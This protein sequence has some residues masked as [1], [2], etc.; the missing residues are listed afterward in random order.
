MTADQF[1]EF[2]NKDESDPI[3]DEIFTVRSDLGQLI[4]KIGM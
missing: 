1:L 3:Y 4:K 2:N